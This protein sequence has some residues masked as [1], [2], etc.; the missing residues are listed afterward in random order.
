M[1]CSTACTPMDRAE[2]ALPHRVKVILDRNSYA[3][4]FS[5]GLL[6]SNKSGKPKDFP[7]PFADRPYLLHLGIACFDRHFLKQYCEMP[8]T[9]YMVSTCR[10]ACSV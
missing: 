6:P 5:R 7:A 9:P 10:T 3:I 1:V 2:V 4:Y 8:A